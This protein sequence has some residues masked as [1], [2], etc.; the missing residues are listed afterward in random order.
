M[1]P[2]ANV[3]FVSQS[4]NNLVVNNRA[5][6]LG[7]GLYIRGSN[8]R[9]VHITL[10]HNIGSDGSGIYVINDWSNY[11]TLAL[12]NTILVSR[13]YSRGRQHRNSGGY[14]VGQWYLG[15]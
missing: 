12:T 2:P 13:Y 11:S 7:S 5:N 3:K 1:W 14:T 8:P 4:A 10:A 15:Q 9:L 6:G